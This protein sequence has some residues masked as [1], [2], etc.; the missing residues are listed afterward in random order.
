MKD[1]HHTALFKDA[2]FLQTPQG[3]LIGILVLVVLWLLMR[4][5][6]RIAGGSIGQLIRAVRRPLVIGLAVAVIADWVFSLIA[7][8]VQF[9]TDA[10][11]AKATT[12]FMWAVIGRV[13]MIAGLRAL[14]SKA[15]YNWMEREIEDDRERSMLIALLDRL[16]SVVVVLLTFSAIILALGVSPT[17]VG[18]VLGGAGIGIGFGTQQISQNFLSGLMLFFNRPFAEGDWIKES[19]FEGTVER[20][21]WYHTRIRTFDRRPLF[22][23]NSVFAT[24]PI[25]NPGRMYNRRIKVEIGLRYEDIGRIN[26][27]TVDVKKMLYGHPEIDQQQTILVNFNEWDSSSINML[28]YCFTKTTVWSDWLDVQQ[29][30]F[31]KIAD[32]VSGAGA[33]FAFPSTTLYPPSNVNPN[34]PLF[35]QPDP[36]SGDPA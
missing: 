23:P 26:G 27:I 29:D 11:V 31:L 24:T 3:L 8:N 4:L 35:A 21:G 5:A 20:I 33:E 6:E 17:A 7:R 36:Q 32:I 25:E 16:F 19:S 30:V 13:V 34:H 14:H 15:F 18:A 2:N 22:I 10:Q 1:L 28:V 12:S 9:L